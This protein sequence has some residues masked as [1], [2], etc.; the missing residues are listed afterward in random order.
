MK[1]S[2]NLKE[3]ATVYKKTNFAKTAIKRY[4]GKQEIASKKYFYNNAFIISSALNQRN[5]AN[6]KSKIKKIPFVGFDSFFLPNF[7]LNSI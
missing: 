6:A 1:Q 4:N 7:L 3:I 5:I 2:V